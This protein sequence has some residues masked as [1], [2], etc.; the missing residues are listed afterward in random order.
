MSQNGSSPAYHIVLLEGCNELFKPDDAGLQ[1]DFYDSLKQEVDGNK[2]ELLL[3][4]HGY[5][6]SFNDTIRG[7]AQ[8]AY[9]LKHEEGGYGGA[10]LAYDWASCGATWRY[11]FLPDNV[12]NCLK[13]AESSANR[14]A[15]VLEGLANYVLPGQQVS[16]EHL[17]LT[18]S[19]FNISYLSIGNRIIVTSAFTSAGA[20]SRL[21]TS[22]FKVSSH[23][24]RTK[25]PDPGLLVKIEPV[26]LITLLGLLA[27]FIG[28]SGASESKGAVAI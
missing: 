1:A 5:H 20:C 8:L 4:I 22:S 3:F 2:G 14:L 6:V 7:A 17:S 13:R 10:V 12:D 19:V 28:C 9:D 18:R 27:D 16:G 15:E 21:Y 11:G 24:G 23:F 26:I 25:R